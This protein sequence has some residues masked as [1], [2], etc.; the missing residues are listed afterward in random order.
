M[1]HLR[2][3]LYALLF[4]LPA[5]LNAQYQN[6]IFQHLTTKDGLASDLTKFIFQ[7]S[8]GFYWLGF[9]NGFQKFD[10]KNFVTTSFNNQYIITGSLYGLAVMPVEDT[11]GNV[12][13]LNQGSIYV[14]GPGGKLDTIKVFDFG[15]NRFSEIYTFCKDD[16]SDIWFVSA[17]GIY[18][19]DK[20]TRVSMLWGAIEQG[21]VTLNLTKL[22]YD[23]S[24]KCFWLSSNYHIFKIDLINKIIS[25]PFSK[26]FPGKQIPPANQS[27]TLFGLDSSHNLWT[28]SW[29]GEMYR[30][31]TITH[32]KKLYDEF[33]IGKNKVQIDRCTPICF[34]VDKQKNIWVGCN[35]G[36]LFSYD[37]QNDHFRPVMAH[38]NLPAALHYNYAVTFLDQDKEGNI[39]V[40]TDRG[41]NIFNPYIPAFNT[42]DE[43]SPLS[44][45]KK[46]E[47]TGILETST[48]NILIGTWGKGW[49]LYDKNFQLIKQ[50]YDPNTFKEVNIAY[51]KN[52]VWCFAEGKDKKIRIGYQHGLLGVFDPESKQIRFT[53]VP[54]FEHST[55]QCMKF[56][57]RGN[58]WFGLHSGFLG[59]RDAIQHQFVVYKNTPP[60]TGTPS[61]IN[62][63]LINKDNNIWVATSRN[64]FYLFNSVSEKITQKYTDHKANST[65]DNSVHSFTLIDDSTIA[66]S[67][68]F[69]GF[70]LFNWMTQKTMSFSMKSG[71][72]SNSIRGIAKDRHGNFWIAS[73]NG[74]CRM[75]EN[76][77]NLVT[78]EE[79]DGLMVKNFNGNIE[80]LKNGMMIIPAETGFVY[81]DPDKIKRRSVPPDVQITGLAVYDT[82]LSIDSLLSGNKAIELKHDQNFI[83]INYASLSF[84]G[85]NSTRYFYKL[86]GVDKKWVSAGTRRF[87]EYTGLNPGN[88]I[89]KIKCVNRDGVPSKN[90]S[91]MV[92]IIHSPWWFT[93]W[94][95]AFYTLAIG[96]LVYI[97][98]RS[99]IR[100]LRNQQAAQIKLMIATQEEERKRISRDLHDD[101]GTKLSALKLFLSSLRE[102]A[103]KI[104]NE[105][106]QMLALDSEKYITETMKDIRQL[107]LNLSPAVLEEFGYTTAVEGIVN[108]INETKKI[109]FNLVFFGIKH[110]LKKDY[111]LALFRITQEL[112][113]NV[114][115]HAAAQNVALQIGLRDEKIILMIEDDGQGFEI[116]DHRDGYGLHN[117][118]ARTQMMDGV[119]TIDAHPGKGTTVLIEIPYEDA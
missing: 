30:Y 114:L 112:I 104:N 108:K 26:K 21:D 54:E 33:N 70:I 6:Y 34:L 75:N 83:I 113:N 50:F 37:Q 65:F 44:T 63:L 85:R 4:I 14:Y 97:L 9:D 11:V 105:E 115:K 29:N 20:V 94:A 95:Y 60:Y 78:F 118:E 32:Q 1:L 81:F 93:W 109:R 61:P 7:D 12:Y 79:E 57:E 92:I 28:G 8:K 89:F 3:I 49:F 22:L 47:I 41:I 43:N 16:K 96:S 82:P 107:L 76:G 13:V 88:Y 46:L 111:E 35:N 116:N 52:L 106:I 84:N 87:T 99:R 59:K 110:R 58:L 40:G 69:K 48:G 18:K 71:L 73:T 19:Y 80:K 98:Y 74:L 56:D 67:T 25:E 15:D 100:K 17:K 42:V 119:M 36:G 68:M 51:I 86:E 102:K 64:G 72:P 101:V 117:L 45:F 5:K 53:Y 90:I 55:I 91:Q 24:K 39:W 27:F 38:N 2:T 23:D 62:D 10:G 77:R 103:L 31:N 66:I